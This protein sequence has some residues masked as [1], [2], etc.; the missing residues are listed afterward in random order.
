MLLIHPPANGENSRPVPPHGRNQNFHRKDIQP[1]GRKYQDGKR[2]NLSEQ[3]INTFHPFGKSSFDKPYSNHIHP[4]GRNFNTFKPHFQHFGRL[5]EGG[6]I[7][8]VKQIL[9]VN[10]EE[11]LVWFKQNWRNHEKRNHWKIAFFLH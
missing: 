10:F 3:S 11:S 9:T 2:I 8:E 5:A 7:A 4:R 6:N 1:P